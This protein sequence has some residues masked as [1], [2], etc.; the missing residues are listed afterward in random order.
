MKRFKISTLVMCCLAA[1][2]LT[3]A[4]CDTDNDGYKSL[5]KEE[6]KAAFNTV[7]GDYVGK[8]IYEAPNVMNT[9]DN[10]DT[11]AVS[12]S[13]N[14]DSTLH[15]KSF[16][17]AT[18]AYGVKTNTDEAKAFKLAL[19]KQPSVD[20]DCKIGFVTLSPIQFIINPS[21]VTFTM[22]WNGKDHKVQ[23]PFMIN[24][25]R[26]FGQYNSNKNILSMQ[27]AAAAIYVDEKPTSL[28]DG[29]F[30]L[31]ESTSYAF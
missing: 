20:I 14:T 22:N 13:I 23:I 31:F 1:M 25:S 19:E 28:M 2:S 11:T 27:I 8:L 21:T 30:Y 29:K 15:V 6:V 18:I 4:S 7:K 26:S 10:T 12:W 3:L 24:Y 9:N 5:T 16:P 17:I